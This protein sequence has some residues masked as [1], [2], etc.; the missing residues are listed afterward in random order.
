M[1]KPRFLFLLLIFLTFYLGLT[2]CAGVFSSGSKD[3]NV[4]ARVNGEAITKEELVDK[5]ESMN[6]TTKDNKEEE[7]KKKK[8]ALEMLITDKLVDQK[9]ENLDLSQDEDWKKKEE[10]HRLEYLVELMYKKEIA[11]KTV[12]QDS[13]VVDYYNQNREKLFTKPEE[14][15][16][17]HILIKIDTLQDGGN[18]NALKKAEE[19]AKKKIE[20]IYEKAI[21]GEDFSA[22]A[23]KYSEEEQTRERGG[24]LGFLPRDRMIK[25]FEEQVTTL[26][27]GEVSKPF[28]TRYGYHIL[29]YTEKKPEELMELTEGLKNQ[30][31]SGLIRKKQDEKAKEYLENLKNKAS[32]LYNEEVLKQDPASVKD[33]PWVLIIDGVD[34]TKF[35]K[36]ISDLSRY[37]MY[38]NKDTLSLED[39]KTLLRDYSTLFN[40][41]V[42]E[43][44]RNGYQQL[45]EYTKEMNDFRFKEAK[46]KVLAGGK[47]QGYLPS[48]EEVYD[49]YLAHRDEFPADSSLHVYHIIFT[50]SLKALEVLQK[51]KNGADFVEMA[52]EYYPGEKEIREVAYD[53]GFIT[54]VEI[55]PEFYKAAAQLKVG[56]VG[57]PVRT[58]W[59]YH[60]IKLVERREGS[61][62]ELYKSRLKTLV[63]LEKQS[64]YQKKWEKKLRQGEEIWINA[65]LIEKLKIKPKEQRES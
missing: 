8:E 3:K 52:K 10:K 7:Q 25:E 63:T 31:K 22:L 13:Q 62:V 40:I 64:E 24:E 9:A 30:I 1:F 32:Y 36:Y 11:E 6:F 59:G 34:T 2:G 65:K 33:D 16:V 35:L 61:P 28:R 58:E 53:L 4:A 54:D 48:N 41:L 47:L 50:D 42:L 18:P 55:S 43:G 14:Y 49:Y 12:V 26:E 37:K 57:G 51:I 20:S 60:L 46:I 56:E 38:F 39:K 23:K 21:A 19:K 17:S 27:P 29:R 44:K 15:K 5:L 45:P